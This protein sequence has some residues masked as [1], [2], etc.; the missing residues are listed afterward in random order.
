MSKDAPTLHLLC[1]KIASGKSTLASELSRAPETVLISEDAWLD[2][3]FAEHMSTG[4]DYLHYSTRLQK[5]IAPHV[6]ALLDAGLSVILD[7]AAN[8]VAQRRWM[9]QIVQR[10]G[11][12]HQMHVLDAPDEVCLQRLRARNAEGAHAFAATEAQFH[13]FTKHFILPTEDEGFKVV[14]HSVRS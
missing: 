7:F 11:V 14:R 2:A 5:I 9:R 1:G 4:A 13:Q 12:A 10:A 6:S 3:L 8:T